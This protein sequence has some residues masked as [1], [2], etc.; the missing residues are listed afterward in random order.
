MYKYGVMGQ[1]GYFGDVDR[2][3]RALGAN[4][5][6]VT[7]IPCLDPESVLEFGSE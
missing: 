6:N 3:L 5:V 4:S 1:A 2:I 7:E